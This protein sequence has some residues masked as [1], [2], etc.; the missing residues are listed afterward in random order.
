M[1]RVS[2]QR[3]TSASASSRS[4]RSVTSSR[5]PIGVAQTASG[6][7]Y[8]PLRAPRSR[9]G[10]RRS[11]PRRRPARPGRSG[12]CR[13]PAS[14]LRRAT[15]SRAG[16]SRSSPAP[17]EPA[18]D[19]D[20]LGLEDV[21]EARDPGAEPAPDPR[22]RLDRCGV[23]APSALDEVVG[24]GARPEQLARDPV[25]RPSGRVSTRGARDPPQPHGG[26]SSS[27]TMW[28][29]S[30]P[31]P[32]APRYG[33]PPRIRP[34]PTPVPSVSMTHVRRPAPAPAFHSPI[35][36]AVA[37]LSI[38]TGS[39]MPLL[40]PRAEV[41]A[42]RAGRS[43]TPPRARRAGRSAKGCP[44]P[45]AATS[46][47]A[48]ETSTSPSITASSAS[49]GVGVALDARAIAPS[50]VTTAAEDLRPADV[51]ADDLGAPPRAA[52][53]RRRMASPGGEK[54]YRV[55]RGG[56]VKGRVPTGGAPEAAVAPAQAA[57]R[58]RRQA[59]TAGRGRAAAA[60]P[61]ALRWGREIGI[62]IGCRRLLRLL[63]AARLLV[64]PRRRLRREQAAAAAGAKRAGAGQG[65]AAHEPRPRSCCS[66]PTTRSPSRAP[67]SGTPTRSC[68]LRTDPAHHRLY[69]LSIPRDLRVEIP[70]TATRRS[71]PP[72]RSAAR[73]WRHDRRGYTG[74]QVNHIVVVDFAEFSDLIDRSAAST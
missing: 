35:A 4:T 24:V 17:A 58:A 64:L 46:V 16:P 50:R 21:Q 48:R 20:Q 56:R 40:R 57:A 45:S 55:Y 68:S 29:S 34:P 67:A 62:A 25:G 2:S 70:A 27:I 61:S 22:Q 26:P 44:N 5:L 6:T 65:L 33:R 15:T 18:A 19:H 43:P 60:R 39:P 31:L 9:A 54:P 37:S 13:A 69:Y 23:P 28:P 73:A 14:A 51:D 36:A 32:V 10:S 53:I 3:T 74:I 66:E 1:C 47:S 59:A 72:T 49:S 11:R 52:T 71:T 7:G 63:G 30:A 42:R 41:D 38:P 12:P 8:D